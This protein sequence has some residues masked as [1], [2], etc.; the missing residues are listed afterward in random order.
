MNETKRKSQAKTF[1]RLPW[2]PQR[3]YDLAI[4]SNISRIVIPRARSSVG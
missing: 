3:S 4:I 2:A 1:E